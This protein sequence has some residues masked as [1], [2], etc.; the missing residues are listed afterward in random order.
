MPDFD[1]DF[2][3]FQKEMEKIE[4]SMQKF[5]KDKLAPCY[6]SDQRLLILKKFENLNLDCLCLD[7]RYMDIVQLLEKEIVVIKDW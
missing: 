5:V 1:N 4:V 2:V 6:T 7:R 3:T